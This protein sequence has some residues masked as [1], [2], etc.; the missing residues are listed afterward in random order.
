[1]DNN[2]KP[3]GVHLDC[4]NSDRLMRRL[5]RDGH[6]LHKYY[7]DDGKFLFASCNA[8]LFISEGTMNKTVIN[9]KTYSRSIFRT[10]E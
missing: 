4:E 5:T 8:I 3:I 6:K 7:S 1:M 9:D 10:D 2:D